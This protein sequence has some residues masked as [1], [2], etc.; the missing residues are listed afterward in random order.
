M[1]RGARRLCVDASVGVK[2]LLR[3][4]E[5]HPQALDLLSR[6]ASGEVHLVVPDLFLHELSNAL[7]TAVRRE[8]VTAEAALEALQEIQNLRLETVSAAPL[9][10]SCLSLALQHGLS[11]YDAAYL[12][13][14]ES[15]GIPLATTD[16]RL[17]E[18]GLAWVIGPDYET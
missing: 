3:D 15:R 7:L 18:C 17:L 8:R 5:Q 14:A 16:R 10:E 6:Y 9:L 12:A 11:I 2:W 1:A 13:V 4:E